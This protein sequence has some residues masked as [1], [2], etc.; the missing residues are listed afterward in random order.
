VKPTENL[1]SSL[2]FQTFAFKVQLPLPRGGDLGAAFTRGATAAAPGAIWLFN[3]TARTKQELKFDWRGHPEK[4]LV[5]HGKG[6]ST[7][8]PFVY[9]SP[10][11]CSSKPAAVS[12]SKCGCG[13]V[14]KVRRLRVRDARASE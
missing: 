2:C 6:P 4:K 5:L 1:A 7:S 11:S 9:F 13:R 8:T 3:A 12:V 10:V 14:L